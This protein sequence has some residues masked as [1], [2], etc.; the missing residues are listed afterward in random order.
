MPGTGEETHDVD[1]KAERVCFAVKS[2]V[3]IPVYSFL[4]FSPKNIQMC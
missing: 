3:M 1:H 4:C 2:L